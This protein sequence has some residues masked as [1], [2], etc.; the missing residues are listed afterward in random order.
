M[1][2]DAEEEESEENEKIRCDHKCHRVIQI[3][4][5]SSIFNGGIIFIIIM[6]AFFMA[7][8]T[9][10]FIKEAIGSDVF[11]GLD[12]FFLVLYSVEFIMKIYAEPK[13]YWKSTYNLF[14]IL[15]LA[16]SYVQGVMEWTHK[17]EVDER[18][19][20]LRV[21]RAL[22]TLR[23]LRTV[24]FIRGLQVSLATRYPGTVVG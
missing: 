15:V 22:R 5:E 2:T 14:D 3:I 21:L 1:Y 4:T 6:N 7:L 18:L 9:D 16:L 11:K 24:S 17:G 20:A 13:N 8:E 19:G 12:Y 10:A 23:T